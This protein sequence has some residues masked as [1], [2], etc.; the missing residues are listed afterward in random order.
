MNASKADE[1]PPFA[2][3]AVS[4]SVTIMMTTL[5]GITFFW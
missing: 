4:N 5:S 2:H 1:L 3:V